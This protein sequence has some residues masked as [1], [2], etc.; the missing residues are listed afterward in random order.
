MAAP[1]RVSEKDFVK[2][3]AAAPNA[4]GAGR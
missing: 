4:S 3:E 2:P 1:A